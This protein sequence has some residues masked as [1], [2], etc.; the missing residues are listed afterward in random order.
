MSAGSLA[1]LLVSFIGFVSLGLPDG[2]IGV[3]WP[4]MRTLFHRAQAD[5][6][7]ILLAH[8]AAYFLSGLIAARLIASVGTTTLLAVSSLIVT[9]GMLSV[10]VS[11]AWW[12]ALTAIVFVGAGSGAINTTINTHASRNF[13]PR[14]VNWLHACYS[15]GAALGPLAMTAVM[16]GDATWQRGFAF[17]A[18]G[19]AVMAAVYVVTAKYWQA[20]VPAQQAQDT[21]PQFAASSLLAIQMVLFFCYSGLELTLGRWCYTV[22]TELRGIPLATAGLATSCFFGSIFAGRLVLGAALDKVGATRMV[23]IATVTAAIGT[24]SFALMPGSFAAA[25]LVLAG[26]A[27]APIFPTLVAQASIRFPSATLP[28][29]IAISVAAAIAGSAIMPYIAG[30]ATTAFGLTAVSG[31]TLI[32]AVMLIGLHETLTRRANKVIGLYL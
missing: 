30:L 31:V 8:G 12:A 29:I 9:I 11:A 16:V 25:G 7:L 15:L 17:I 21:Q 19:P 20:P 4:S 14:H 26:F 32:L 5:F 27:L 18:M 24:A 23:R 2:S 1:V 10:A 13:S 3:A 6:G 28:R 22:L